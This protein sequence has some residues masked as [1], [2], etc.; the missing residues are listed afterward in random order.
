MTMLPASGAAA[1]S[2]YLVSIGNIHASQEWV[3]TPSGSWPT[4]TVNVTTQDQTATTTHTPAWAIVMVILFIWVFFLSLLFLLAKEIRI[5]GFV[6]VTI[7][8]PN[9]QSYTENVPIWNTEQRLDTFQRVTYL[10][11]VIGYQ[12]ARQS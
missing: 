2:P 6:N 8:G 4:G 12:R 1:T 9:G 10:Q 11:G 3:V 5:T 7:W